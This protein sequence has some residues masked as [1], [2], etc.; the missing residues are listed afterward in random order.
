MPIFEYICSNCQTAFEALVSN[1]HTP[2]ACE[3]C[4]S[5]NLTKQL[6]TFSAA[7][8]AGPAPSPCSAGG[9]PSAGMAGSGCGTGGC[10]LSR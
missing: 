6:S 2:V 1:T 8:A 5:S 3:T 4:G 9:C 10:P 7:V